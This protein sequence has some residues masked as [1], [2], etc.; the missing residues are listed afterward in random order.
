M[1][2][3]DPHLFTGLFQTSGFTCITDGDLQFELTPDFLAAFDT[4]QCVRDGFKSRL[5]DFHAA[6]STMFYFGGHGNGFLS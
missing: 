2:P 5:G 4:D 3:L 1:F 6:N